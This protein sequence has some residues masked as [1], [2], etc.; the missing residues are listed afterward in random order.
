MA[1][2]LDDKFYYWEDSALFKLI[3]DVVVVT[4]LFRTII[5][6]SQFFQSKGFWGIFLCTN[7]AHKG[8]FQ[9]IRVFSFSTTKIRP[10]ITFDTLHAACFA[11]NSF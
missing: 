3:L 6:R 2:D 8:L 7:Y 5:F 9:V 1:A 10:F 11:C 4:L